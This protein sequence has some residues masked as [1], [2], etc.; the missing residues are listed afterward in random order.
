MKITMGGNPIT[1]IGNEVKVGDKAPNFTALNKDLSPVS[2]SDFSGKKIILTSFPSIDTGIC[3]MQTIRFNKEASQLGNDVVIITISND[4]PFAISRYC[5]T[6]GIENAVTLSDYRDIEFAN[7]YGMLI[8]E[9]RLLGRA[10]F[11]IDK[12]GIIRHI[13]VAK[14]IKSELNYDAAL[15]VLK[16]I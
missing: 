2:L 8:K 7:N 13:E 14:E 12:D 6:N 15:K 11:V 5:A 3:S 9:L 1:L 16:E 4:L 10:V